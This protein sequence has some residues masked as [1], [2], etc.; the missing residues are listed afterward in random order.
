MSSLESRRARDQR[1]KSGNKT[2]VVSTGIHPVG[3]GLS[4]QGPFVLLEGIVALFL[5]LF[6]K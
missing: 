3:L 1:M 5:T 6:S 4:R 2:Q